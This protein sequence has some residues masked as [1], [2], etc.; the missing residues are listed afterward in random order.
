[1]YGYQLRILVIVYL[2]FIT[3][4][5]V[6]ISKKVNFESL[7]FKNL[8]YYPSEKMYEFAQEK[9][10][11]GTDC[12]CFLPVFFRI[13]PLKLRTRKANQWEILVNAYQASSL[14]ILPECRN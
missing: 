10:L 6:Y 14:T 9:F 13:S 8:G 11:P 12:F 7:Y 4:L 2:H 5:L 1:M 3:L